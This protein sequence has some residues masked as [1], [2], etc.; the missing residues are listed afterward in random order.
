MQLDPTG[1][2]DPLP[3]PL[4]RFEPQGEDGPP[5]YDPFL[6]HPER[7]VPRAPEAPSTR[8]ASWSL[9]LGLGALLIP[10]LFGLP[11]L[12]VGWLGLRRARRLAADGHDASRALVRS[13]LGLGLGL[14]GIAV[15]GVA[16]VAVLF[17]L[18]R[19][20]AGWLETPPAEAAAPA[21][22]RPIPIPD[23]PPAVGTVPQKTTDE[24][25]GAIHVVTL[26]VGES[27][28]AAALARETAAA[29]ADGSEVLVTTTRSGCEPCEG[30]QASIGDPLMQRAFEKTRLVV[31]DIDVFDSDLT[32]LGIDHDVLPGFFL[33]T[34]SFSPR[35]AV[36]G[37][38]WGLDIAANIAPVLGPFVR[39]EL[40]HRKFDYRVAHRFPPS[41]TRTPRLRPR[42]S[43]LP[44]LAT[45]PQPAQGVWL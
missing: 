35:D 3:P 41:D 30:L 26:G 43:P 37:G 14:A 40:E 31:V 27:S 33:L 4:R 13:R 17:A 11:A 34:P 9:G 24:V 18:P 25:V 22:P 8:L 19:W 42:P 1:H 15:H 12:I 2:R 21:P 44:G 23:E 36:H 39:G 6:R 32:V 5:I 28:L 45:P 38:E 10:A 7:D 16:V 20:R 29:K